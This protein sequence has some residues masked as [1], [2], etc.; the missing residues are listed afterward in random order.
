MALFTSTFVLLI[1]VALA[2]L[3]AQWLPKISKTY[4]ALAAGVIVAL[5]PGLNHLVLAFENETFMIFILA[6]LLFFEGQITP[7]VRVSRRIPSILG[8]A[9]VLAIGSAV[10]ATLGLHGLFVVSLPVALIM[11]A[12]S[13]PTDATAFESVVTGRKISERLGNQLK[14]ESLF[15]DATGLILLQAG[16]LWFKTSE[17]SFAQN[18]GKLLISAVGGALVGAILAVAFM[19]FRQALVRTDANVVSSQSLLYLL[20]PIIIYLLAEKLT[21]S[22]I[23]AVV[24]AG[25]VHNGEANSS[26][27][28]SP[29][30]MYFGTQL[31]N[32]SSEILNGAVFVILGIS[33]ER[34]VSSQYRQMFQS[35]QWLWLGLTVYLLLV[36]CR[37]VYAYG[38]VAQRQ[39]RDSW[40]FALGGV[41]GTVTLA[42]TFSIL[43]MVPTGQFR[44]VIL[45]ETV[46]II[47]SMLVPT[48][49]FKW[50]LP[51]D[52]DA[53]SKPAILA[54]I[55]QEMTEVG[56]QRVQALDL[57]TDVKQTV[58]YELRDQNNTNHLRSFLRRWRR[59]VSRHA[60]ITY[61]QSRDQRWAMM[62][63][64][65]SEREF[66]VEQARQHVVDLS[67]IHDIYTEVL[68]SEALVVDPYSRMV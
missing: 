10:V 68:M 54:R 56:I 58:I 65:A 62:Q 50:L 46:V 49:L 23:I 27:F 59:T 26:R 19:L 64:F 48:I 17:F 18:I 67:L 12:I 6:P 53:L 15:N 11:V 34:I 16:L 52:N 22:G 7:M 33:L 8:T 13:T 2:N 31:M 42:M 24:V 47:V 32:F 30:Q 38:F 37:V 3:V 28:S 43:G 35:L 36:L 45:V 40:L 55:R 41:H 1:T 63:A 14:M 4:F 9:F 61:L 44:Q 51:Q 21:V 57:S 5:I 66:L 25:L 39:W 60:A 29:R 20:T